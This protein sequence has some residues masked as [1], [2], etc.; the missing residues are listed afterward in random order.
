MLWCNRIFWCEITG[1]WTA[2]HCV[3]MCVKFSHHLI[4]LLRF[5]W[6]TVLSSMKI[7]E[8]EL[9]FFDIGP[10]DT[11]RYQSQQHILIREQESV[12]MSEF[13]SVWHSRSKKIYAG[14]LCS[15]TG[16][17]KLVY[18]LVVILEI[19][20][21]SFCNKAKKKKVWPSLD[22]VFLAYRELDVLVLSND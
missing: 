4:V 19:Y 16:C 10:G 3:C 2:Q 6:L 15:C 8:Q 9:Y 14:N 13:M 20:T 11:L 21:H 12:F 1:F 17:C 18:I 5:G 22:Y 7:V